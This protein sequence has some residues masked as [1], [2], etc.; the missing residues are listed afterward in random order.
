MSDTTVVKEDL[1]PQQNASPEAQKCVKVVPATFADYFFSFVG[2]CLLGGAG[3]SFL[4]LTYLIGYFIFGDDNVYTGHTPVSDLILGKEHVAIINI[5][6]AGGNAPAAVSDLVA[7]TAAAKNQDAIRQA[8]YGCQRSALDDA[9]RAGDMV[10][11]SLKSGQT[12][13]YQAAL[14]ILAQAEVCGEHI[15]YSR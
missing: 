13:D 10:I 1:T 6:A 3:F 14:H 15:V 7:V 2:A 5:A 4:C 12:P 9:A 8:S 11:Q